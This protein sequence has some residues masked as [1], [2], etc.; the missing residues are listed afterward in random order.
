L[1]SF[2]YVFALLFFRVNLHFKKSFTEYR[3][4]SFQDSHKKILEFMR[5][6]DEDYRVETDLTV[7]EDTM[8]AAETYMEKN[9]HLFLTKVSMAKC[10]NGRTTLQPDSVIHRGITKK[11]VVMPLG[12]M[13]RSSNEQFGIKASMFGVN[14]RIT[15]SHFF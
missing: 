14:C 15:F 13:T 6:Y 12:E 1:N 10:R 3:K 2:L 8:F 9:Q 4:L 11:I 5:E 7:S